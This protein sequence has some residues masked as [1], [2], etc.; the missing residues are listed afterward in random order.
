[1][2]CFVGACRYAVECMQSTYEFYVSVLPVIE[3]FCSVCSDPDIGPTEEEKRKT[4]VTGTAPTIS[5]IGPSSIFIT[6]EYIPG[7]HLCS[8][9][10][11]RVKM[12]TTSPVSWG[13]QKREKTFSV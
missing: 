13:F 10:S 2:D 6:N 3:I 7:N 9:S 11:D 4:P 5:Y 1:M 8:P 12:T